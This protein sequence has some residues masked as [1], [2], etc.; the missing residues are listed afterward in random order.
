M[1]SPIHRLTNLMLLR[2]KILG[3]W[4]KDPAVN[5]TGCSSRGP[6]FKSHHQH[7]SSKLSVTPLSGVV[8]PSYRYAC[9]KNNSVHKICKVY[10]IK[11]WRILF[12]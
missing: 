12:I 3:G 11:R 6:G 7:D 10:K 9:R 2:W 5:S 1:R 4:R 8:M